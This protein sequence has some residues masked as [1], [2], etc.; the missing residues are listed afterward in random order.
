[1]IEIRLLEQKDIYNAEKLRYQ[2]FY[3]NE[4]PNDTYYQKRFEDGQELG[5]LLYDDGKLMAGCYV[6]MLFGMLSIDYIF[7]DIAYQHSSKKYGYQLL[8]KVLKSKKLIEEYFGCEI[9]RCTLEYTSESNKKF[10]EKMG[11]SENTKIER[12]YRRI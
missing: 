4:E 2:A 9:S 10:Y 5:F 11:F 3:I 6:S 8:Q 12:M 1:M 7:V